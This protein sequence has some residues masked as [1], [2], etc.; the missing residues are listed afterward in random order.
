MKIVWILGIGCAL[1]A[2]AG[3]CQ[4]LYT[5]RINVKYLHWI[6]CRLWGLVILI[7]GLIVAPLVFAQDW[8][9]TGA[10]MSGSNTYAGGTSFAESY[11]TSFDVIL[12]QALNPN[13]ANQTVI[14]QTFS[15]NLP[16]LSVDG[17][18]SS[19]IVGTTNGA[20]T[21]WDV[22][23][24]GS[25]GNTIS[26]LTLTNQGDTYTLDTWS[27][28]CSFVNQNT[29]SCQFMTVSTATPGTWV[30]PVETKS[31]PEMDQNGLMSAL[32]L[33]LGTLFILNSP[34]RSKN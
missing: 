1:T 12:S 15:V 18:I 8:D 19:F 16:L 20:I 3:W 26:T 24:T 32:S 22:T 14:P 4:H 17:G 27:P 13:E 11:Q 10:L 28:S 21:S 33:L 29:S 9:Y 34:R 23:L 30:D 31:A 25:A 7:A 6:Q 5:W 2:L